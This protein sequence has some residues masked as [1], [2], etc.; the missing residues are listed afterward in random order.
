MIRQNGD[1]KTATQLMV[2]MVTGNGQ[3]PWGGNNE[4]Y[5]GFLR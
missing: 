3:A 4:A 5:V 2:R 1:T